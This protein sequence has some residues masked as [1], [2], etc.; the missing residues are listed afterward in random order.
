ML[1]SSLGHATPAIMLGL[2]SRAARLLSLGLGAALALGLRRRMAMGLSLGRHRPLVAVILR[3]PVALLLGLGRPA[4]LLVLSGC[5]TGQSPEF[6]LDECGDG[7]KL[8][9]QVRDLGLVIAP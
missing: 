8:V 9:L 5:G 7:F 1:I 6:D 4:A 3:R 2:G